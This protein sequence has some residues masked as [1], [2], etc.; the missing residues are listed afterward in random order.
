MKTKRYKLLLIALFIVGCD[1]KYD[2]KYSQYDCT[3]EENISTEEGIIYMETIFTCD[4][5]CLVFP[6]K[7]SIKAKDKQEANSECMARLQTERCNLL[8][9]CTEKTIF[10]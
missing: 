8:C 4:D 1:N 9:T 2:C 5:D 6:P 10:N 7:T 3:E